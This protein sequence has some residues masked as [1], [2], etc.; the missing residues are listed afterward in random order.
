MVVSGSG[1]L[2]GVLEVRGDILDVTEEVLMVIV[3]IY[4]VTVVTEEVVGVL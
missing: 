1:I 2:Q 3:V 4:K